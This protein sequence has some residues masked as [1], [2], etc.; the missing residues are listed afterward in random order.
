MQFCRCR[1]T[2]QSGEEVYTTWEESVSGPPPW[3]QHVIRNAHFRSSEIPFCSC[4]SERPALRPAVA[5]AL[6]TIA[7]RQAGTTGRA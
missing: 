7:Q 3:D 2:R 6:S 4:A 1:G 5:P